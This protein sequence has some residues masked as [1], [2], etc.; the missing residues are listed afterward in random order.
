VKAKAGEDFAKLAESNSDCPSAKQG[1][2]LDYFG[3][4]QMVKPFEDAAF[5]LKPGEMSGVVETQFGYHI[6]KVTD[7]KDAAKTPFEEVK[8]RITDFLKNNKVK[9]AL[10]AKVAELKKVAKVD[11]VPNHI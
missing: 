11:K 8:G 7:R 1:G 3:K 10:E 9:E 2:D 4:G 6:I 5:A